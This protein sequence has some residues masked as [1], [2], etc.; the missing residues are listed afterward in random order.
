M[1]SDHGGAPDRHMVR[2]AI[3][4]MLRMAANHTNPHLYRQ[5]ADWRAA[6]AR[7]EL[8]WQ[9]IQSLNQ[10]MASHYRAVPGAGQT[11]EASAQRLGRRQALKLLGA[12]AMLG[13]AGW[14]GRDLAPWQQWSS[15]YA[16][17]VGEQRSFNLPDGSILH[18][19]THSAVDI[20]F[21][22]Q[23]RLVSL[24]RGEIMLTCQPDAQG[25]PLRVSSREGLFEAAEA[26]FVVRQQDGCTGLNVARGKVA[27]YPVQGGSLAWAQPGQSW[28]VDSSGPRLINTPQM[29][30]QAWADGLIVTRNMRLEAF[31]QEIS[32]Y[33]PGYLS[34]A[35][36]IA[37]LR[38]SGVFR[39]DDTDKLLALL[40][41]T[42]P[43]RLHSRT[44]FWLRLERVA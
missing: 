39:L 41:H 6:D 1:N 12:T 5:C 34:C 31:V 20:H 8:A 4:W 43:V 16:T 35:A 7:H 10:E 14:L 29:D 38:L 30:M 36:D 2:Q 23:Q 19:N 15:D 42:L 17:G 32:R 24:K 13:G 3:T 27:I 25:R 37:D 44:R 26:R 28:Q 40:P 22:H 33:R 11:L 9:R 18:L 21:S